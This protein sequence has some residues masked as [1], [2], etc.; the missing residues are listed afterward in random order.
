MMTGLL[1]KVGYKPK[2]RPF[3]KF[4]S[5][6]DTIAGAKAAGLSV[7]DY[8]ERRHMV[9]T[10][11]SLEMTIDSMASLGV[12]DAPIQRFCEIGP[13]SGRYMEKVIDRCKPQSCEIYE[14]STEWRQWLVEK[15]GVVSRPCN[16]HKLSDT[17][18]NSVDL[19]QAH[20]VFPGLRFLLVASYLREMARV[21]RNGGW[22][23]FDIM[24]ENCFS[25]QHLDEWFAI[26]PWNWDWTPGM[27][28]RDLAIK[29]FSDRGVNFIGSFEVP[30]H[31]AI[32]E[33]MVFRKG[34]SPA[35]PAS[36][37]RQRPP[38]GS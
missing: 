36:D 9:G 24:T 32:T 35:P 18:D 33:C 23:V 22:I 12:F 27:V 34:F 3:S 7:S 1:R 8:I 4:I 15:Y 30:Q 6:K 37:R 31:P 10:R 2:P 38:A 14:T 28:G 29:L 17:E 26:D 21:T 11:T 25:D 20:K 16:G 13:G 19:I 5:F